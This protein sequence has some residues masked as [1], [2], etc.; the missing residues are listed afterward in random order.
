MA[1][2]KSAKKRISVINAKTERNKAKKSRAKTAEKRF[3]AAVAQNNLEEAEAKM[4]AYQK[5]M[6]RLGDTGLFHK[7]KTSRKISRMRA[8]LNALKK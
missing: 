8:R 6:A 5:L 1:N 2:I 3:L 4:L 7:N